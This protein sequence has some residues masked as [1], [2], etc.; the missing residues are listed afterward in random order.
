MRRLGVA[1]K[2]LSVLLFS[3]SF[4]RH[5][6]LIQKVISTTASEMDGRMRH[7]VSWSVLVVPFTVTDSSTVPGA[8]KQYPGLNLHYW[9]DLVAPHS[10]AYP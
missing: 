3:D 7:L 2:A 9:L 8:G 10:S 6:T 5:S 1:L 4:L